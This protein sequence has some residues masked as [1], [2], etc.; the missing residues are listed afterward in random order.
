MR[1]K[2]VD[3]AG[4]LDRKLVQFDREKRSL[5]GI[6]ADANRAAFVSTLVESIRRV[7][8]AIGLR[9]QAFSSSRAD[10]N[11]E[12]FDPLKAAVLH[13]RTGNTD[14]AFWL[15][16]W[17]IHCGKHRKDGWRL[18]R[19]LYG[20][21]GAEP[22]TWAKTSSDPSAFRE[23]LGRNEGILHGGDGVR[24][25][26]GNHRKYESLKVSAK[27]GTA[28]VV[29]SYVAWVAPPRTHMML[30]KQAGDACGQQPRCMFDALYRSL[31]VVRG[32]GRTGKFDYLTMLG[33]LHLASIEPGSTYKQGATGPYSGA[34]LL[35][36]RNDAGEE[37]TRRQ[38]DGFLIELDQELNVGMQ[39]WEDA[40]C[41]WQKNPDRFKPFRG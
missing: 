17:A 34:K 10:P 11:S 41:N 40:L 19:D 29:E 37:Y 32:F 2:I 33:K 14:E 16:F 4:E 9:D 30:I 5:P 28:S 23:W 31:N 12:L 13:Q 35:F 26:F 36:G 20:A 22:W 39:V 15:V 21:L 24:R 1:A 3:L 18:A 25:R 38:V 7:R 8:F 6:K 27:R